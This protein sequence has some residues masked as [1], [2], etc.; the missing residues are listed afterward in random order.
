MAD[1]PQQTNQSGH[2]VPV[3]ATRWNW[4]AFFWTWIWGIRFGVW[5]SLLMFIPVFNLFWWFVLGAKGSQWAWE[6]NRWGSLEE[7]QKSQRRWGISGVIFYVAV[8][9]IAVVLI[10]KIASA[11]HPLVERSFIIVKDNPRVQLIVGGD[12]RSIQRHTANHFLLNTDDGRTIGR[13]R[14]TVSGPKGDVT[15]KAY[16]VKVHGQWQVKRLEVLDGSRTYRL[17]VGSAAPAA[18]V[19]P[20]SPAIPQHVAPK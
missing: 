11:I 12:A 2:S 8:I 3:E 14:Y 16:G 15:V 18:P 4:G 13:V 5:N 20:Q 17:Q 19:M 1:Q 9:V 6:K 7:F 10:S